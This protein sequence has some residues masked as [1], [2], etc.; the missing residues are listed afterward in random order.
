VASLNT[1]DTPPFRA[2]L[3]AS[4]VDERL[5]SGLLSDKQAHKEIKTRTATRKALERFFRAKGR[6]P[7]LNQLLRACLSF[8]AASG[9][10]LLL[11][12]LEDL[13]LESESQNVPGSRT[14]NPNWQRKARHRLE[15]FS[16]QREVLEVL[17]LVNT[18]RKSRS[19]RS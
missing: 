9:A 6:T 16:R 4:D 1:H 15:E 8:L 10:S 3:A 13:W 19:R 2:F 18:L 5:A 12:N 11:I 14:A 17:K 7:R